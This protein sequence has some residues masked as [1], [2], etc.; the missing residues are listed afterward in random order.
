M[1]PIKQ[2]I[3]I[4]VD[5]GAA[6]G[7]SSTARQLANLLNLLYV[8]TGRHYRALTYA[9]LSHKI[10]PSDLKSIQ[11]LLENLDLETKIDGGAA[12]LKVSGKVY[13]DDVLRSSEVN[14][15]VSKFAAIEK[16]RE[17]LLDYQRSLVDLAKNNN[18]NGIIME[19]RDVG[20]VILPNADYKFFLEADQT[21]RAERRALQGEEDLIRERDQLDKARKSAP[22]KCA[23]DAVKI[24]TS[25]LSLIEVVEKIEKIVSTENKK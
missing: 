22:L 16:V 2:C 20:S 14:H 1:K 5:G 23:K 24:D 11:N 21:T 13:S 6:S 15:N 4:A 7:K 8:D 10:K 25:Q 19:G 17:A 18:F 12:V 9:C 3:V